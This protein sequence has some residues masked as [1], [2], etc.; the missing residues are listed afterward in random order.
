MFI[1]KTTNLINGKIYIGQSQK[2]DPFYFGSG[3]NIKKAVKEYG[4]KNFIREI[5]EENIDNKKELD[6]REEYWIDFFD[7]TNPDI[8]YNICKGGS[9]RKAS[10]SQETKDRLS[11]INKG[12]VMSEITKNKIRDGQPDRH[13]KNN[14][15]Y[16]R[17]TS[18]E[19][20]QKL[21]D[22]LKGEKSPCFGVPKPLWIVEKIKKTWSDYSKRENN[23]IK[24]QGIKQTEGCSSQYVGVNWCKKDNG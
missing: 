13:G 9:G 8:G 16:N 19:T 1:Y 4:K 14:P 2:K 5:V 21:S 24:V 7:S 10:H 17:V 12:K 11:E 18:D 23:S 6:Q 22:A 20:K 15:M 3:A